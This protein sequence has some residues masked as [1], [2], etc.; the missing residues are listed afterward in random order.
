MRASFLGALLVSLGLCACGGS[1]G[2]IGAQAGWFLIL[3][4]LGWGAC[5]ATLVVFPRGWSTV[6]AAGFILG[7]A[8][9]CRLLLL[10]HPVSDDVNRYLWEGKV[11]AQGFSPYSYAPLDTALSSL[12]DNLVWPYINHPDVSAVYPPLLLIF[13]SLIARVAY[14][15]LAVKLV[16]VAFDIGAV[17]LLLRLLRTRRLDPRWALLYALNPVVLYGFAGQAHFDAIHVFLVLAALVL[18]DTKAW[19]WMFLCLGLAV[20]TKYIAIVALP[21][22]VRRDNWRHLWVAASVMLLPHLYFVSRDGLGA[23]ESIAYFASGTA[24][25]GS[26]HALLRAIFGNTEAAAATCAVLLAAALLWGYWRLHPES[27][28]APTP[29]PTLGF[30]Y[31]FAAL[32][33]LSP[34]VHFWYVAWI[35]PFVALRPTAPLLVLCLTVGATFV[36]NGAQHHM[37]RW[38][39]PGWLQVAEW[40]PIYGLLWIEIRR[41]R[42]R[43]RGGAPWA[44]PRSVSVVIPT[45][46]EEECIVPCVRAVYDDPAVQEVIVVDSGSDDETV[47]LARAS[48]A[49]VIVH[50]APVGAG[51]G[52]GGQ[53]RAGVLSSTGDIV[54]IVHADSRPPAGTF[55]TIVDH[56]AA[57]PDV[58]GGAVGMRFD[59]GPPWCHFVELASDLRAGLLGMPFGDQ[60][61]FF[62]R[63]PALEQGLPAPIPLMEDVELSYGLRRVGRTTFLWGHNLVSPRRWI[64]R[65]WHRT[66]MVLRLTTEY[67]V[68][69]LWQQPDT[70]AMYRN[71]YRA[72]RPSGMRL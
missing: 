59:G 3:F 12:R 20:Q 39:I 53:I 48:G 44:A 19:S 7:L 26:I 51:G 18:Y 66:W 57:Q 4:A 22:L 23:F 63:A 50:R 71:Y 32:L 52:R 24:F 38:Q 10:G 11:L 46:N 37:G 55:S 60:L 42:A 47:G 25:N 65:P 43:L 31:A 2:L 45:R 27:R 28:H 36:A 54:A 16:I 33:L 56:L 29:D 40:L 61:Q 21:F 9:L 69:R 68:R 70:V 62:R 49:S 5:I 13:F 6:R 64:T 30:S 15:T 14:S 34:T 8:V 17:V 72:A 1:F 58:I 41:A 67:A 35:V